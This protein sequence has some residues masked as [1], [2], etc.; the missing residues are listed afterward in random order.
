MQ[1][2]S[3]HSQT[4]PHMNYCNVTATFSGIGNIILDVNSVVL[5]AVDRYSLNIEQCPFQTIFLHFQYIVQ[6]LKQYQLKDVLFFY[7]ITENPYFNLAI[8]M[9]DDG[10]FITF[11]KIRDTLENTRIAFALCC[12]KRSKLNDFLSS[13]GLYVGL[14]DMLLFEVPFIFTLVSSPKEV[15]DPEANY[16]SAFSND[17]SLHDQSGSALVSSKAYNFDIS[18][19]AKEFFNFSEEWIY[20]AG[21]F[22]IDKEMVYSMLKHNFSKSILDK[23]YFDGR[24]FKGLRRKRTKPS[25]IDANSIDRSILDIR[26]EKPWSGK[27]LDLI[28]PAIP[29]QIS[30]KHLANIRRSAMSLYDGK[31]HFS[32]IVRESAEKP[33]KV[34]GKMLKIIQENEERI[35]KEKEQADNVWLRNFYDAY[36][37]VPNLKGK[38]SMLEKIKINNDYINRRLLL[39]KIELYSDIWNLETRN[40][41]VDEKVLVPLYLSCLKYIE[42]YVTKAKYNKNELEFVITKLVEARFEATALEILEKLEIKLNISFSPNATSAP[43]DLDLYFQLKYAGDHLKRTLGTRKDKRVPFDPDQWQVNLLDAVDANKS[44]IVSAPTSSGKTFICFYAIEKILRSSDTDMVVFCLPTKALVNQVSAD[45]YA[46]FNSKNIKVSLQGTLM[47]DRCNDPFNCQVLITVPA[48]LESLLNSKDCSNIK[49]IIIDEVHKINDSSLGLRIER[50]IHLAKCPLLL[51]SATLG[52]LDGFY[53][54]FKNIENSKGRECELV[55]HGERYCELKSYVYTEKKFIEDEE[56][57]DENNLKDIPIKPAFVP[58]NGMFPYSFSHL[59]NFG[60]GNDLHFLPEELLN[61]YLYIYMI[62]DASHKKLIKHLAPKKFF[63]SNIICKAD[64]REYQNHLLTTFRSWVSEGILNEKQVEEIHNLLTAE[65]HDAFNFDSSEN[66]IVDNIMK[67][68]NTLKDSDMLPVI[69]FNTDRDFV[70]RLARLVYEKLEKSDIKKKKDKLMES[71][72]KEA[73][74]TRDLEKTKTSWIE[75]SIA[76]EQMIEPEQ[77]DIRFTFLDPITKLTDYEVKEEFADIKGI[78][79]DILDMAFRGIGIHHSAMNRKYRSAVEI[80]FRKK[81][82]RVLFATETLALGINMPCRT[83]VFAGDSLQLDPMN[84][85]QMSGRAGRRGYDTLGNVVFF[86]IPK[87]RV[88]NLMVSMLPEIQGAYVYSNTSLV[89]FN[90]EDSLVKYPLLSANRDYLRIKEIKEELENLTTSAVK[91]SKHRS[92]NIVTTLDVLNTLESRKTLVN[93]QKSI[94]SHIFPSNY[95]W[96]LFITNREFDPS[97]FIFAVLFESNKIAWTSDEF[98]NVVAHLFEVRLVHP[99]F[100]YSLKPLSDDLERCISQINMIYLHDISKFYPPVLKVLQGQTRKPLFYLNSL[101]YTISEKKNSYIFDFYQ[102]GSSFK[103]R[104]YNLITEGELWQSLNNI[105]AF[106]KSFICLLE[107]YYGAQDERL[108]KVRLIYAEFNRKFQQIFA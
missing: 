26:T 23:I 72:K 15:I 67:L 99:Q 44:A 18:L 88:Q 97:I 102:H 39:L 89:S 40:E 58:L 55:Y 25:D 8:S 30:M 49:Y 108:K 1:K 43:N 42:N 21:N 101:L 93:Y 7:E 104:K 100:E 83:V 59:K 87:H 16:T 35:R 94:Y 33:K 57:V 96:D 32:T 31:F 106:F 74:R 11:D 47:A 76:A 27:D 20:E 86:G 61:I 52:N 70:T 98:M 63:Q 38:K 51:L 62:L 6:N 9:L 50:I 48:M 78:P 85:K 84:Y 17:V 95:L 64:I 56:E 10:T 68:L 24:I 105:E 80:L 66:Y 4:L 22:K 73:K 60:F 103:I 65:A 75:E 36:V 81:H 69:V 41:E 28:M 19:M 107:T 82:I 2:E 54:W 37:K 46:R 90:I 13:S 34:S 3:E 79:K 29:E 91:D 77:R 92:A 12:Y 53:D 71:L 5:T 45:I 14:L